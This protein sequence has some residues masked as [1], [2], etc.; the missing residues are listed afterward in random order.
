MSLIVLE[1]GAIVPT[2]NAYVGRGT[3][4][5]WFAGKRLVDFASSCDCLSEFFTSVMTGLL[6]LASQRSA[7]SSRQ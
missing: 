4:D 1:D 5:V 7:N 3:L 6:P 2:F